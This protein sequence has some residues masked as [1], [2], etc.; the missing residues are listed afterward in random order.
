MGHRSTNLMADFE[1]PASIRSVVSQHQRDMALINIDSVNTSSLLNQAVAE[2]KLV[3]QAISGDF[4]IGKAGIGSWKSIA[5]SILGNQA[6]DIV[7]NSAGLFTIANPLESVGGWNSH[8]F[9]KIAHAFDYAGIDEDD[10][11][12]EPTDSDDQIDIPSDQALILVSA[13]ISD[14]LLTLLHGIPRS[15]RECHRVSSKN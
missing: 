7:G 10:E 11:F 8:D 9:L 6:E 3:Q 5:E 12:T 1:L 14:L 2:R 13:Q 4:G 15:L